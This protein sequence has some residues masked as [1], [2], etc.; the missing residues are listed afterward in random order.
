MFKYQY[1][2]KV[3]FKD[4]IIKEFVHEPVMEVSPEILEKRVE[5]W[6]RIGQM[7][8]GQTYSTPTPVLVYEY[9]ITPE[10]HNHN[11]KIKPKQ[12]QPKVEVGL[13]DRALTLL[14]EFV[15]NHEAD[16][17]PLQTQ[18]YKEVKNLIEDIRKGK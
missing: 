15:V 1:T 12:P 5:E 4:G 6:N 14:E 11:Y 18:Q 16:A 8:K 2:C 17:V 9:F 3:F 13:L 7:M 10:Q